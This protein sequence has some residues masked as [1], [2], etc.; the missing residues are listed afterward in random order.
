M[1]LYEGI[2]PTLSRDIVDGLI[3]GDALEIAPEN[4]PEVELDVQAVL[5]EYV[6]QEREITELAKDI[7][8][9]RNMAYSETHKIKRRLAKEKNFA[10][11]EELLDYVI[12]QLIETFFHTAYVDEVFAEDTGLRK[13]LA[14]ILRKHLQDV[15]TKLDTEVRSRLKNLK[16]GSRTW[17]IEYEQLMANLKRAKN[18]E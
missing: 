6:R 18:V 17:E 4:V 13:L 14:P 12:N 2:I 3:R 10:L 15:D 11:G 7:V 9:R 16:E 5:R 8:S 1:R